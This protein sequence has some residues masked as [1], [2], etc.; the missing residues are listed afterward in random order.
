MAYEKHNWVCGETITADLLNN[1]EG[2]VEEA[3]E[4]CGSG[5]GY[6][7]NEEFTLLTGETVTTVESDVYSYAQLAYSSLIDADTLKVTFNGAEYICPRN[8]IDGDYGAPY[9]PDTPTYDWSEYP[10]NIVSYTE[11][12]VAISYL[13]TE[14][15]GTYTIKIEALSTT[16]EVSE[17]F[18]RAVEKVSGPS[19]VIYVDDSQEVTASVFVEAIDVDSIVAFAKEQI[20]YIHGIARIKSS[21]YVK[22]L[23][24]NKVFLNE[25]YSTCQL[26]FNGI[27]S[28]LNNGGG[29]ASVFSDC[30]EVTINTNDGSLT[31]HQY[32]KTQIYPQS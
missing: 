28:G 14:T 19:V 25:Y 2:G 32:E 12:G 4:C 8:D 6:G 16:A 24:L 30:V 18:Q 23:P 5:A 21:D 17:C 29:V 7:C 31:E 15:A 26:Q 1:L 20:P 13:T 9:D 10:F 27:E 22:T 3:L 11:D